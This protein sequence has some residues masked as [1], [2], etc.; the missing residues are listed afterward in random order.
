MQ[1]LLS[2]EGNRK[3]V[4]K[5][6]RFAFEPLSEAAQFTIFAK[7]AEWPETNGSFEF[8]YLLMGG[9]INEKAQDATAFFARNAK[10]LLSI[11][12][13]WNVNEKN[14]NNNLRWLDEFHLIIT[15][16]TS[17]YSYVNFIDR[18]E[19]NFLETYYGPALPK[20]KA[21]KKLV[22]PKNYF[23]FPQGIPVG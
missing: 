18:K 3:F 22:D 9:A 1:D 12:F 13:S 14:L 17:K 16:Q 4:Y 6:S 20:L 15:E 10:M 21:V 8:K 7:L 11:E 5:R 2:E 23:R 19:T